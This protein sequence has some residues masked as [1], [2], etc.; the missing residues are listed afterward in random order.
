MT[1]AILLD[2]E[3]TTT[4]IDFVANVLFPYARRH[5]RT[6]V[7]R[8]RSSVRDA[9]DRLRDD[10]GA[11]V[12]APPWLESPASIE[13]AVHWLMDR[14]RKS[15]GLKSLQGKIWEEGYRNGKLRSVVFDDVPAA[16]Q[17]WSR[18][19]R[20][21]A[22]FS[23]GSVLAQKLLFAHTQAGDLTPLVRAHFDTTIGAKKDAESYGKIARQL[24]TAAPEVLFVSDVRAEI[25]AAA[26]A[27]MQT[28][29]CVRPGNAP[30]EPGPHEIL[31]NFNDL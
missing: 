11:E 7:E 14:D 9:L 21:L 8:N 5:V 1:S 2:V 6:F 13:T 20:T 22:V 27:G 3:G 4:P 26:A 23:S 29:L 17:R 19:G 28:R 16:L 12:G 30:A 15:T 10:L 25:D 18:G 31:R 24:E